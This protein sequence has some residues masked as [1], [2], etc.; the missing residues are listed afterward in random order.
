[1][2]INQGSSAQPT[3]TQVSNAPKEGIFRFTVVEH[4]SW[5]KDKKCF[6]L[7]EIAKALS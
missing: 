2:G 7:D 5:D 3:D 4:L 6:N 1:M